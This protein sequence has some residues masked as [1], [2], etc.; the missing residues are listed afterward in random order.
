MYQFSPGSII[1]A[2]GI[3]VTLEGV[4]GAK[5]YEAYQNQQNR[6]EFFLSAHVLVCDISCSDPNPEASDYKHLSI[7]FRRY[8]GMTLRVTSPR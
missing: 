3:L 5:E 6:L 7:P 8:A 2:D 1:P 4:D